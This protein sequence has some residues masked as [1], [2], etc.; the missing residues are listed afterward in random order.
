[1]NRKLQNLNNKYERNIEEHREEST[2]RI[3]DL[4]KINPDKAAVA[5][6]HKYRNKYEEMQMT[7]NTLQTSVGKYI[8]K[9]KSLQTQVEDQTAAKVEIEKELK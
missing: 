8:E 1:M 9:N 4:R 6:M 5:D 3:N 7:V 2:R